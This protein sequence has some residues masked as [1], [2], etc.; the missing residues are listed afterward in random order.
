MGQGPMGDMMNGMMKNMQSMG[1]KKK[2]SMMTEMMPKC[3]SMMFG[4]LEPADRKDLAEKMLQQMREELKKQTE[5]PEGGSDN[6]EQKSG[7]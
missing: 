2:M 7:S 6:D 5:A 3:M 1:P 4:M